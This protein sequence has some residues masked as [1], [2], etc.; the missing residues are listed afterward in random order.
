MSIIENAKEIADLI[1]KIGDVELYRRI[2]E[3][4]GEIIE[5][6]RAKRQTEAK[7][8]RLAEVLNKKEQML[9]QKPF[10]YLSIDPH[11]YCPQRSAK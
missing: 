11:P 2:V 8:E 7:V 3:L 9:F 5:L 4:E 1:K 10:Y 6:T